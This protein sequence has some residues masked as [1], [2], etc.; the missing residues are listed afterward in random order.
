M[1]ESVVA[2]GWPEGAFNG[3]IE[4]AGIVGSELG[5]FEFIDESLECCFCRVLNDA[6]ALA[7]NG[8]DQRSVFMSDEEARSDFVFLEDVFHFR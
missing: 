8:S 1:E 2:V 7:A 6:G 4:A 5:S 3:G